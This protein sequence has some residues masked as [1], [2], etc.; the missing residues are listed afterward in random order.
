MKNKLELATRVE[1][2]PLSLFVFY[3]VV[4]VCVLCC[5]IFRTYVSV[6]NVEFVFWISI[7]SMVFWL[8]II[9]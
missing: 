2:F 4:Y 3:Y 9:H 6:N 5:C 8:Y 1:N 7:T